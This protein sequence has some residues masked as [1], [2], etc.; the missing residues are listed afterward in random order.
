MVMIGR[1]QDVVLAG[2]GATLT[3]RER[4][5][6]ARLP[7]GA[8]RTDYLAAHILVRLCAARLTGIPVRD[9]EI[10][11]TCDECGA[12][13]HG[14]PFV[15]GWPDLG[16]SLSHTRGA[17]AAV[18]GW[19]V[20]GVDVENAAEATA[21]DRRVAHRVLTAAELRAVEGSR[22]PGRAFLSLWVRKEALI[23]TGG[24]TVGTLRHTDVSAPAETGGRG[25][26]VHAYAGR[27]LADWA[28]EDGS[29]MAAAVTDRPPDLVAVPRPGRTGGDPAARACAGPPNPERTTNHV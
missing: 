19:G 5:R 27:Y 14:R 2:A 12:R 13:D 29:L 26:S 20:V 11:Q 9:L 24:A 22:D 25:W 1:S 8:R 10:R 15:P 23:K 16:V 7:A 28:S 6:A 18:A 3:A 21:F 17:V 4:D